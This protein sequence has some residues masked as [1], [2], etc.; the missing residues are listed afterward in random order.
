M[1]ILIVILLIVVAIVAMG[2]MFE[3]SKVKKLEI[4]AEEEQKAKAMMQT[5]FYRELK[6]RII[7]INLKSKGFSNL[8]VGCSEI[9]D[10]ENDCYDTIRYEDLGYRTLSVSECRILQVALS[11]MEGY[12][13]DIYRD[14]PNSSFVRGR[15]RWDYN[16]WGPLRRKQD[17]MKQKAKQSNLKEIY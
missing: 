16:Y 4:T 13:Y 3:D 8:D 15:V 9:T 7:E 14:S 11:K 5:P 12:K 1:G 10:Y 6:R 17:E 2:Y